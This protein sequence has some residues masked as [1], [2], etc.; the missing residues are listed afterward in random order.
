MPRSRWVRAGPT[1]SATGRANGLGYRISPAAA[2]DGQAVPAR[3]HSFIVPSPFRVDPDGWFRVRL[4]RIR[5]ARPVCYRPGRHVTW[6]AP[7]PWK[8]RLLFASRTLPVDA[9]LV[10]F[11][12]AEAARPWWRYGARRALP[13]HSE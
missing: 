10:A 12:V 9:F 7:S 13:A 11:P 6:Q 8:A 1:V 5:S 3:P 4:V 2:C